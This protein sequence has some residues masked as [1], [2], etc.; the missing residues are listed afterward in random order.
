VHSGSIGSAAA[1][2]GGAIGPLAAETDR[3][4]ACIHC[5]FC[6]DACPTYT[7]GGDESDSPRGRLYLM[8]AVAEGRIPPESDAFK[9]H[10]DRC[11]GCRACEPVCPS[12][13]EYGFLLERGREVIANARGGSR[14]E[15]L[16][17]ATFGNT[18][19]NAIAGFFAR[20]IRGTGLASLAVRIVPKRLHRVR[21][22]A[23]MLE[24]SRPWNGLRTVRHSGTGEEPRHGNDNSSRTSASD[25]E[26]RHGDRD[27]GLRVAV[28]EGCVQKTLFGRANAATAAVLRYN[29]H[30]VV[31]VPG[32]GC[33]GALHAHAGLL[34][35][36][37]ALARRNLK[38]L[39]PFVSDGADTASAIIVNAAGCGS[40]MQDYARL[41]EGR[42]EHKLAT[43]VS[44]RVRD[45]LVFLAEHGVRAGRP[46]AVRAGWD[47]PCHLIHGQRAGQAPLDTFRAAVPG[48]EVVPVP[49]ADECCGGAGIHALI[50]T[51]S[52]DRILSDK[53]A[54]VRSVAP[55]VMLTA[56]PG[57][58]MQI[59]GGLFLAGESVRVIHPIEL[60]AAGCCSSR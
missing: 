47:S 32:L 44:A 16:L 53:V 24:A 58:I 59:G 3:L 49:R 36:A 50:H 13:V 51:A 46:L 29:G 35:G 9:L 28:F 56:N 60:V 17:L 38:A 30:T 7:R 8:R 34:D 6:L 43:C 31:K 22:A 52:G 39:E 14:L 4:L 33:C 57:C 20:L 10:L 12:G 21:M 48:L 26:P 11:L 45:P 18:V 5:G 54:A 40:M 27:G 15:W 25:R 41:F 23:A 19:M 37:R 2:E 55:D 42:P 1:S